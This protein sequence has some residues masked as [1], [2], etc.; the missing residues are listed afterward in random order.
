TTHLHAFSQEVRV[1]STTSGPLQWVGGVFFQHLGRRYGQ[2]LPTPGY[3]AITRRL[4]NTDSAA[5]GSP[6]DTPFFSF[7][8]YTFRQFAAF[9]EGT[10]SF[11][12]QWSLTAGLR[13]Y[14]F[15]EHRL[16]TF[17]GF[18]AVPQADVPGSVKSNGFTPR[19]IL[20]FKPTDDVSI[21]A[22]ISRGFRLGGIN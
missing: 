12:D 19:A 3:D 11:N 9:G 5:N 10:Y 7:L 2:D 13:Y 17:A 14:D 15:S 22:Q 6:P 20:T 16:L 8:R 18:F 4:F 1:A 21:S